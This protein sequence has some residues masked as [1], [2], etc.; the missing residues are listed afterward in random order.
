MKSTGKANVCC[1]L[2]RSTPWWNDEK[3]KKDFWPKG[4]FYVNL[5]RNE[6]VDQSNRSTSD[7]DLCSEQFLFHHVVECSRG[8]HTFAFPVDFILRFDFDHYILT[9]LEKLN[10]LCKKTHREQ[11]IWWV[12]IWE[13]WDIVL[14]S[15]V[16][17]VD[18]GWT[19]NRFLNAFWDDFAKGTANV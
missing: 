7:G 2:N 5:L 12:F 11:A 3:T 17:V 14:F 16:L 6:V 4:R 18:F 8:Q 9:A 13:F 15:C 1:P 19:W 10:S